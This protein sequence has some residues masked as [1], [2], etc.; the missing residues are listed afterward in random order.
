M[1][2]I[3]KAKF[4]KKKDLTLQKIYIRIHARKDERSFIMYL[5]SDKDVVCGKCAADGSLSLF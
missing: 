3:P 2:D 4:C 1:Y 5:K